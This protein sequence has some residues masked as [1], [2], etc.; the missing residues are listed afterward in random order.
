MD[1][2]ERRMALC[3]KHDEDFKEW[4]K[5]RFS[6]GGLTREEV[7]TITRSTTNYCC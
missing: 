7:S 3:G 6:A 4:V 5:Q 2:G 1:F